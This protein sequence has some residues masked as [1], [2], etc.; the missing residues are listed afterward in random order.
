MMRLK[1]I[2][3]YELHE[4][5]GAIGAPTSVALRDPVHVCR[6]AASAS[7]EA[8]RAALRA[9][10]VDLPE[11]E[12]DELRLFACGVLARVLVRARRSAQGSGG[13]TRRRGPILGQPIVCG[14]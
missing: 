12:G 2:T 13:G 14:P 5:L 3:A 6:I 1:T 9:V 8:I 4:A 11:M 7:E 10:L